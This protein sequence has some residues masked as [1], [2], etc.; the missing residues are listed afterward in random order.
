MMRGLFVILFLHAVSASCQVQKGSD[1]VLRMYEAFR[2]EA[3]Q[4][5]NSF[6]SQCNE[7]YARFVERAWHSYRCEPPIPVPQEDKP[8]PP[9]PYDKNTPRREKPV[10]LP[11]DEVL[12]V[13]APVPQ[14]CPVEPVKEQSQPVSDSFKFT[15]YGTE[16]EVRLTDAHRFRLSGT[17]EAGVAEAWRRCS[18]GALDNVLRD[19]LLLR[20]GHSLCDWAYL[21]MLCSLAE[22][23]YGVGT[24]EAVVFAGWLYCQSGYKMRLGRG[25][26]GRLCLLVASR[27]KIYGMPFFNID[28]DNYYP[29]GS[30]GQRLE[31]CE[32]AFPQEQPMSLYIVNGQQFAMECTPP[33]ILQS[34]RYPEIKV[35]VSVNRNMIDFYNAYPASEVSDNFMTRWAM[36]ANTPLDIAVRDTLYPMLRCAIGNLS[37]KEA[38]EGL[39]NFVQ[40][41]FVYE[42]DNTVWGTD[43]A[44]FAEET[45]F[46]PYCDCEDRSILFSRLVRDLLGL[47]VVL[48]YY[49]GHLASAVCFSG[50]DVSGDY[51]LLDNRRFVICDPT[52]IGAGI[53]LTMPGM[54]NAA[55]KVILLE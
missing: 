32:A 7:D 25:E 26:S 43:R 1:A 46:Y 3:R 15:C 27:H 38:V 53:G 51:L 19:C 45:L 34:E 37:S 21:H 22:A 41:A 13:P 2:N 35:T 4:T 23:F 50:E 18:Q 42:Y 9:Q 14:P 44:F 6:R 28:G 52:Y 49:P 55:A 16:M 36:Y 5:Y 29:I 48:V 39:L 31:I 20:L 11:H 8:M 24:D 10:K 47:Q 40:T 33:R 30:D 12:P 17:S 54:D